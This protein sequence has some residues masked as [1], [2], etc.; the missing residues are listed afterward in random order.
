[1][2]QLLQ[3]HSGSLGKGKQGSK[4]PKVKPEGTKKRERFSSGEEGQK[5]DRKR[6]NSA[7]DEKKKRERFNSGET[8]KKKAERKRHTSGEEDK[9]KGKRKQN[10]T[11]SPE[12][13]KLEQKSKESVGGRLIPAGL[14]K[15][16]IKA[17][18][19]WVSQHICA[20]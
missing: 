8:G 16:G 20:V 7:G 13:Y 1:M 9:I 14:C 10:R 4:E 19:R 12:K 3:E 18:K 17:A 11:A 5:K 15:K 2:L 6:H